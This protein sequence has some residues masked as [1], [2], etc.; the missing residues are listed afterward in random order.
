VACAKYKVLVK[1]PKGKDVKPTDKFWFNADFTDPQTLIKINQIQLKETK[2]ENKTT[3]ERI[4]ADRHLETQAAIV[5]L[6]KSRKVLGHAELIS[7]VLNATKSRGAL[8][9]AEIK[10][11]I[12]KYVLHRPIVLHKVLCGSV[13]MSCLTITFLFR[14]IEKDYME[15]KEGTNAYSYVA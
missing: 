3:H 10:G 6:M 13:Y 5:R 8:Q 12:E 7:E 11:E 14:L 9:P 2:E 15:R 1:S 4:S